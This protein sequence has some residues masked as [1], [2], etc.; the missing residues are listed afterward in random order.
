MKIAI[1]GAMEEEVELIKGS[2]TDFHVEEF[3]NYKFYVG[4]YKNLE[5]IVVVS[6]IGKV[7]A[8]MLS[9]TL[10]SNFSNIDKVINVGVSGGVA[11]FVTEGEVVVSEK[12]SYADVD[13]TAFDYKY[14]Q[15]AG[16]PL[17]YEGDCEMLGLIKSDC[18]RGL[19]LTGDSF[20]TNKDSTNSII[21]NYFSNE[22]VMCFDMESTAFAQCAYMAKIPFVAIRAISD[23]IG[24]DENQKSKYDNALEMAC[25]KANTILVEVLEGLNGLL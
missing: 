13:V 12:L 4:K 24:C 9:G 18:Y 5:L 1:I 10:F 14:G 7:A 15:M 16:L 17:F 2:L 6:K 22:K 3:N 25:E 20:Q 11:G 19:L 21:N 23:V 8:G